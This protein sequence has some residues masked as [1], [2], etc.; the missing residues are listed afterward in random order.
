MKIIK[1]LSEMIEEEIEDAEKYAKCALKY[2]EDRPDLSRL[3]YTLSGEEMDHMGRLH[4]AVV[5]IIDEYRRTE[6]EPPEAMKAVYDYLHEKQIEEA[7]EVR[8][9]QAMYR[10]G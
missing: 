7:A 2:K 4:K 5:E 6:G 3:F 10:E 8:E 9:L 1:K